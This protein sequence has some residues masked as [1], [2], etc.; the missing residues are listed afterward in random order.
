MLTLATEMQ[1][2]QPQFYASLANHLS[3]EEQGV[4]QNT[5]T[6]AD[7]IAAQQAQQA[8][9]AQ[10]LAQQQAQ[11]GVAPGAANGGAS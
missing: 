3:A 4:I 5:M 6:K 7:E 2:E 9:Q 10:L 1:Q 11:A 8:Q